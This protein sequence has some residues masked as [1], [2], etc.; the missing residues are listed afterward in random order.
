[1]LGVLAARVAE[2]DPGHPETYCSY[3]DV[4]LAL[5]LT[6][7]GRMGK[8]LQRHGLKTLARWTFFGNKPPITG[9]I[10]DR[11][12]KMPGQGFFRLYG[13]TAEDPEFSTWWAAQIKAAKEYDWSPYL[14][15]HATTP[16]A[17][18]E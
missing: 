10:I 7:R 9:L 4:Y 12:K 5:G 17:N 14:L 11:A 16:S 6:E 3:K 15:D 1:M 18:R 2:A 13:K 8:I